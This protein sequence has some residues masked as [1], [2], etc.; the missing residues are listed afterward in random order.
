MG[1]SLSTLA[2]I[3]TTLEEAHEWSRDSSGI[4]RKC[5]SKATLILVPSTR[6]STC[7][8]G[9]LQNAPR[10]CWWDSAVIMN[11]WMKEIEKS[12]PY[13]LYLSPF[14]A[15]IGLTNFQAVGQVVKNFQVLR[16]RTGSGHNKVFGPWHSI[17]YLSYNCSKHEQ[18]QQHYLSNWMVQ[19]RS[20]WR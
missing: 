18:E 9:Y 16:Q 3:T 5:R 12:V 13:Y 2:L 6:K 20:W 8:S 17:N 4:S 1:K 11:S 7:A 10:S 19:S 15:R 14:D